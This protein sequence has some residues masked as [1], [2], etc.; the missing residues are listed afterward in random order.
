MLSC[1]QASTTESPQYPS[2]L[3]I[4]LPF[5]TG[6]WSM[7]CH[8]QWVSKGNYPVRARLAYSMTWWSITL[9]DLCASSFP[10][11]SVTRTAS[12]FH[13][14]RHAMVLTVFGAWSKKLTGCQFGRGW[15]TLEK[16]TCK[17]HIQ[18]DLHP[19]SSFLLP[20]FFPTPNINPETGHR[21]KPRN[22]RV[23]CSNDPNN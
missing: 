23:R 13:A 3:V 18:T 20:I 5:E 9:V 21:T 8:P 15:K 12:I 22:E 14:R 6:V 2:F 1:R 16:N 19:T 17:K 11:T 7:Y 4:G 10:E